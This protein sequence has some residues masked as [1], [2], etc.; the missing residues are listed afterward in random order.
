MNPLLLRKII[1]EVHWCWV[2]NFFVF[3]F[4]E[5]AYYGKGNIQTY[6]NRLCLVHFLLIIRIIPG[7][8]TFDFRFFVLP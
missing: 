3:S 7:L 4:I 2:Y 8:I 5:N 6:I 1:C